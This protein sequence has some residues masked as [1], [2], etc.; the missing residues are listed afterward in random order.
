ML[1]W[2]VPLCT[3]FLIFFIACW[4]CGCAVQEEEKPREQF[5]PVK[6]MQINEPAPGL[7]RVFPGKVRPH[8]ET[9]VSFRVSNQLQTLKV[10]KGE[11][12][13]QGQVMA[14]LDPRDF[15]L[16]V[17]NLQGSLGEAVANLKAMQQGARTEDVVSLEAELEAASSAVRERRLQYSRHKDLY[18]QGAVARAELD[19]AETA[20]DEALGHKRHLEMELQKALTGAR[21]EDIQAMESRIDSLEAA[22]EEAISALEDSVLR[23]PFAGYIAEK[24]VENHENISAGQP[25]VTLQ[26]LTRLE[27]EFG[28]PEQMVVRKQDITQIFCVLDAYP[29]FPLPASLKEVSTDARQLSYSATAMLVVPDDILALPSMAAQVHISLAAPGP[30]EDFLVFIPETALIPGNGGKDRVWVYDPGTSRV[31][32]RD[33]RTGELGSSGVQV[34]S[35]LG[36]GDLVVTAGAHFVHEDQKVRP[37]E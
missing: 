29:G 7:Q 31:Q 3:T 20:L 14:R 2:A 34:L 13:E 15:R 36:P 22:L 16:E 23:A 33:V 19:Q 26:D 10:D 37:L 24:H 17:Q 35:G 21:D 30:D 12:V 32:S 28:L 8:R 5:R 27:V 6:L 9:R 4:G 18:Q 25:V 11:F 1:R